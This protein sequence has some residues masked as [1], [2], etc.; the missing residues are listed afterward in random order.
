MSRRADYGY[1]GRRSASDPNMR[2][3]DA[4]RNQVADALS[5]HYSDGR[6]DDAEL[7]QRLDQAMTAKTNAD[8]SGLLSDLPALGPEGAPPS[9]PVRPRRRGVVLWGA[10]LF[11][12]LAA[13][14]PAWHF[15]MWWFPRVPWIL[16]GGLVVLVLWRRGRRHSYGGAGR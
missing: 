11:I 9:P 14:V 16:I 15:S 4:E 12:L 3:G 6:L 5:Q 2:I 8:L 10:L 7:K 13:T 1:A